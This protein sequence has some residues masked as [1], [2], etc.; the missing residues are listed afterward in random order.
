MSNSSFLDKQNV[1]PPVCPDDLQWTSLLNTCTEK[2]SAPLTS[3]IFIEPRWLSV[4]LHRIFYGPFEIRHN[5]PFGI[6]EL[7]F[8]FAP[9]RFEHIEPV[10][11]GKLF[12]TVTIDIIHVMS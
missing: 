2:V 4:S 12:A 3:T 6:C 9:R 11:P 5:K 1:E 7:I 10:S 8:S